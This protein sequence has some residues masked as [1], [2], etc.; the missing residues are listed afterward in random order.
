MPCGNTPQL[1]MHIQNCQTSRLAGNLDEAAEHI[2]AAF[3]INSHSVQV[4]MELGLLH[5]DRGEWK[6]ARKFLELVQTA[7]PDNPEIL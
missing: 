4:L 7:R 5:Q 1:E 2:A 3:Q 6:E